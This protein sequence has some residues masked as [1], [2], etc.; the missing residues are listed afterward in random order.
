MRVWM[1]LNV[2][3]ALVLCAASAARGA[4]AQSGATATRWSPLRGG[5]PVGLLK[6]D[7][8]ARKVRIQFSVGACVSRAEA[9]ALVR[10][11]KV[12]RKP[13]R[14]LITVMIDRQAASTAP[15]PQCDTLVR[16]T[17]SLQGRLGSRVVKDGSRHISPALVV[18]KT[19]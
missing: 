5:D 12:R 4:E 17:V 7:P 11:V 15:A 18:P 1:M 14:V 3:G 9:R 19:R 2:L 10:R 6:L 16:R 8:N 13:H